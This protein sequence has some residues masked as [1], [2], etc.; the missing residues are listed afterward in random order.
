MK[1]IKVFNEVENTN[2]LTFSLLVKI[3][4]LMILLMWITYSIVNVATEKH[5][6]RL[7]MITTNEIY[8]FTNYGFSKLETNPN[9]TEFKMGDTIITPFSTIFTGYVT[10]IFTEDNVTKVEFN[11]DIF[12]VS[13]KISMNKD[14]IKIK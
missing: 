2:E 3:I 7:S 5:N 12:G 8:N 1:T 9:T 4:F 14:L 6:K 11:L 10:R 13:K